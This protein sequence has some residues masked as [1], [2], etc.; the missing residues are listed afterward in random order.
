MN[1]SILKDMESEALDCLVAIYKLKAN[2][3]STHTKHRLK[4]IA[5]NSYAINGN[6]KM[7]ER[8]AK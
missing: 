2:P 4:A 1:K 5:I 7:L 8:E 3:N 6:A